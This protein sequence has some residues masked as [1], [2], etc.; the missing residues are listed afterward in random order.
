MCWFTLLTNL[1]NFSFFVKK[2]KKMLL[3][4]AH[5]KINTEKETNFVRGQDP[6]LNILNEKIWKF[7]GRRCFLFAFFYLSKLYLKKKSQ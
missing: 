2:E 5:L 1:N 7:E 6:V 4:I 3:V